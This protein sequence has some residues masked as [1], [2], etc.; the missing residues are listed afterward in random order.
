MKRQLFYFVAV[1]SAAALTHYLGV[2]AW[3]SLLGL[4]PLRANVLGFLA[5]FVVSYLGHRQW[6]FA[7][8]QVS[9]QQTLPRFFLVALASFLLNQ[10]LFAWMLERWP[11]WPYTL[12]LAIVLLVVAALTFV[13]SRLWAFAG[14]GR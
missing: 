5:A 9:H 8:Q 11:G 3:V 2:I 1:G 7:A 10:G 12:S 6:T 4:S 13:S 14:G